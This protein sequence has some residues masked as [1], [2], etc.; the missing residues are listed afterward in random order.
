MPDDVCLKVGLR[1]RVCRRELEMAE[2]AGDARDAKREG[3]VA[4]LY[5][6]LLHVSQIRKPTE[7]HTGDSSEGGLAG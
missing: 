2:R 6:E 1:L 4:R 5:L 7:R 3:S